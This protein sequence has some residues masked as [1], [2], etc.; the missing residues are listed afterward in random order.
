MAT[1]TVN[2]SGLDEGVFQVETNV[3]E[4]HLCMQS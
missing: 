3:H 1:S 4:E 2:L